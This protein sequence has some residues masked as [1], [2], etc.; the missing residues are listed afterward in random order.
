MNSKQ[1]W[2][3]HVDK[4]KL[5]KLQSPGRL[6]D[7][8]P[9]LLY[10]EYPFEFISN[11]KL[12][13]E[14]W[15]LNLCL[16]RTYFHYQIHFKHVS[17]MWSSAMLRVFTIQPYHVIN[18]NTCTLRHSFWCMFQINLEAVQKFFRYKFKWIYKA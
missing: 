11:L 17:T 8:C 4:L 13:C 16:K 12:S 1:I 9:K 7:L 3:M 18:L 15:K 2:A 14:I 6:R 10:L 5:S